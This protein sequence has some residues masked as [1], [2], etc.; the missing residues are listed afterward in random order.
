MLSALGPGSEAVFEAVSAGLG[1]MRGE[2]Y[3]R[4]DESERMMM[5]GQ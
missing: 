4:R 5:A 3:G 2:T 1:R